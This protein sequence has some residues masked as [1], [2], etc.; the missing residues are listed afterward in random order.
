MTDS[1]KERGDW[2]TP[3]GFALRC[4][5]VLRDKYGVVPAS[6][7]EPTC[8]EGNFIAAARE[9]FPGASV[10]GIEVDDRYVEMLETRFA[11]DPGVKIIQADFLKDDLDE[12]SAGGQTALVIGNPPWV[13]NSELSV[14]GS[15][16]LPVK[17]NFKG[18]RGI[19]AMTGGGNFDICE[20]MILRALSFLAADGVLAMLC[21]TSVARNV[22]IELAKAGKRARCSMI[23]FDSGEVFGASVSACFLVCD[24]RGNCLSIEQSHLN[25]L[26]DVAEVVYENGSLH[27]RLD[28][29]ASALMG[30]CQLA[31]RQGVKHDCGK[32][33]ELSVANGGYTNKLGDVV[34]IEPE[35][36]FPLVKSS[37]SRR[38]VITNA[39]N[40]V[41]MT[42]RR[43]GEDTAHWR[44]SAPKFWG[45][46]TEHSDWFDRRKS[47]IYRN[48]P[49][50]SMFGVGAYSYAPYKVAVSGFY[51]DP[52]FSL[53]HGDKPIMFDDTCYFIPFDDGDDARVCMLL[54][55]SDPV[56]R[57]YKS[58]AFLDSK[59]PYA[60]KVLSQLDLEKAVSRVSVGALNETAERIGVPF[61]VD[62]EMV[63]H[64]LSTLSDG[65]G[66]V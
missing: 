13:T 59:R 6:I 52:V 50:F 2:Q 7:V 44:E 42:Q 54:L 24:F 57:F 36:V 19:D 17:R 26:D 30:T 25:D 53:A 65:G 4:C 12:L 9:V 63:S 11:A 43:I 33:M 28:E 55:N 47:S 64:F 35:V 58:V 39:P 56:V 31:W 20:W 62:D 51:K 60:K 14:L 27:E 41:P 40:A 1:R 22:V 8:G 61:R 48:S 37:K 18:L 34:D 23:A 16:N 46:L 5:E 29:C 38:Y 3:H 49:R 32:V 15:A 45:Y 21:K 10:V 66:V